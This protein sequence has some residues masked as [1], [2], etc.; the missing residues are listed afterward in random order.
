MPHLSFLIMNLKNIV[1][2][3][4]LP[5][6]INELVNLLKEL[7][8]IEQDFTFNDSKQRKGLAMMLDN[9]ENHLIMVAEILGK[10]V[11]MC[12]MQLL[13]STAEGGKAALVEDLVVNHAYRGRG[14]GRNL[15]L[16]I[17]KFIM[18]RGI[19][20]IQLLADQDNASAMNFYK[21]QG[22]KQTKLICLR[23]KREVDYE[24]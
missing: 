6:D 2:R 24:Y 3:K 16:F 14:I 15:L 8:S 10:V 13:I 4:A 19:S 22:W 12:S 23:K 11:G 9:Q 21:K 17:E 7:F 20:R 5:T 1:I 18:Q